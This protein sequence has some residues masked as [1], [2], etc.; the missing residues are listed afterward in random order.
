MS[1]A[2]TQVIARLLLDMLIVKQE[3][4][5]EFIPPFFSLLNFIARLFICGELATMLEYSNGH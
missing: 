5:V 2:S 4:V 3:S 1:M